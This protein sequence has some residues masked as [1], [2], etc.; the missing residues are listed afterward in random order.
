MSFDVIEELKESYR[1]LGPIRK[2]IKTQY[3]IAAGNN[4]K[5]AVPSW[6]EIEVK[7]DSYYD[8][9]KLMAA[10]N[11][12]APKPKDWWEK[13]INEAAE[14][15]K[16]Q[17]IQPGEIA[18]KLANDFPLSRK[19]IYKYLKD[20]YKNPSRLKASKEAVQKRE[21]KK[22]IEKPHISYEKDIDF[23]SHREPK[24]EDSMDEI[25]KSDIYSEEHEELVRK[26]AELLEIDPN[27]IREM[28]DE[29]LREII[30]EFEVVQRTIKPIKSERDIKQQIHSPISRVD[31]DV[32]I[33]L[34][35]LGIRNFV[36]QEPVCVY[37]LI[38]DIMFPDKRIMVFFDGPGHKHDDLEAMMREAMVKRGWRVIELEY[39]KYSKETVEYLV[40]EI[41]NAIGF[42][43]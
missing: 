7:V 3:G 21:E 8:H 10:D 35:E 38:P 14:E 19:V 2:V 11:I 5:K 24:Y 12:H 39:E 37:Q 9:L 13:L 27:E 40:K 6:P 18:R 29:G 4:R 23:G 41:L 34:N 15:L 17:G 33:K 30:R 20:E 28:S 32:P 26:A 16:K 42:Q 22:H 36:T 43:R 1:K 25:H 31:I